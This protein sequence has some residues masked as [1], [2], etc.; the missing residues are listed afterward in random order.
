MKKI[1]ITGGAG[2]AG[3]RLVPYLLENNYQ[4]TVYDIMYFG[5]D[6]LPY[7]L[8]NFNI[9]IIELFFF[10]KF[11]KISSHFFLLLPYRLLF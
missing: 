2:Y 7:T 8:G 4:V 3:G 10:L 1:F 9:F 5:F 6:H 11:I